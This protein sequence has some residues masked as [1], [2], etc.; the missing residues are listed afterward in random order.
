[1]ILDKLNILEQII[2]E[3]NIINE[4]V[5]IIIDNCKKIFLSNDIDSFDEEMKEEIFEYW[6]NILDNQLLIYNETISLKK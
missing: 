6:N 3:K 5:N 1:M 2:K 4:D